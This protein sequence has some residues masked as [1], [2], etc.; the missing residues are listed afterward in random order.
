MKTK[1][2]LN[3][4]ERKLFEFFTDANFQHRHEKRADTENKSISALLP[5]IQ[6][7]SL[8]N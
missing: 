6:G 8:N 1:E 4:G 5:V 7:I 2:K 3:I